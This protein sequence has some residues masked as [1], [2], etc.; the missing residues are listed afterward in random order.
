ML[1]RLVLLLLVVL[2][3]SPVGL[4]AGSTPRL[5]L[6]LPRGVQRG[7][8]HVLRFSGARLEDTCEVFLYDRGVEIIEL[9]QVDGN[10]VDVKIS[11]ASDCRLGEHVAQLRTERGISDFRS[12]HVGAMPER[13][14]AEPNNSIEQ[15]QD[16]PLDVTVNGLITN[17]DV[18]V[19]RIQA[20]QG[21]RLSVEIEAM[22]LGFWFDPV[23]AVLNQ[24]QFELAVSDDSILH[25][26][27]G[28]VSFIIP[29]DGEY[30]VLVREA[31]YGGNE[32]CRYRLH[33]GGFPRPKVAFP[34]GGPPDEEIELQLLGD[35]VGPI[36]RKITVPESQA[37]RSGLFLEDESGTTPSSVSFRVTDLVNHFE[38]EPNGDRRK[39]QPALTVPA[40]LNGIIAQPGDEDH[41]RFTANKGDA[42]DVNCFARRIRSGLDPVINI[43]DGK[44]KHIV[45][46]DDARRP[47][48]Y[49]RFNVPE[50][51]EYVIRVRDHLGRG[52]EEFVY[53][54]EIARAEPSLSISIPRVD[55]Y[56]QL[57]QQI[58]VPQGN[59][60]ATLISASRVNFGGEL[61][62]IAEGLPPGI[63]FDARPMISNLNQM[64]VVFTATED[65]PWQGS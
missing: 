56:S 57:R 18:D 53:R 8:E 52:T 32:N 58:C 6:I 51:A 22:R 38:Q 1:H 64:P 9:K 47:D 4:A 54:I 7:H 12:F 37:F 31:S 23:I 14:E 50:T 13:S 11:V 29:Q 41:F 43:F 48:C 63:S 34:A 3:P 15:P 25:Q 65:A 62:L 44:G 45:G 42:F 46:D 36:T 17:E 55:R 21:Q 24:Q 59:R 2:C 49:I 19:F 28:V 16:I 26:Q 10:N 40:A 33:V 27:D 61:E 60:F 20:K 30:F 39:I 5:N 35:P